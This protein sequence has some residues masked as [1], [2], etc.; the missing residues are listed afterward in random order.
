MFTFTTP[1]IRPLI[2][3]HS[4]KKVYTSNKVSKKDELR[5]ELSIKLK[6]ALKYCDYTKDD[7]MS[8]A[9]CVLWNEID[10]ISKELK[11]IKNT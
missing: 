10:S 9:C 4:V 6:K 11:E 1:Y 8:D 7:T 2:V 3:C 5:S